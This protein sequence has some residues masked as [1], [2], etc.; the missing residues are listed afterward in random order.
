MLQQ[1]EN[2]N[3]RPSIRAMLKSA[4]TAVRSAGIWLGPAPI[5]ID[6]PDME[7]TGAYDLDLA[8]RFAMTIA[9]ALA[10]DF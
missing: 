6:G 8:V 4:M 7:N 10:T 1:P 5:P 2:F 9:P 3:A